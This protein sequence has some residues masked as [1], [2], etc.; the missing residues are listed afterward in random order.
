[1]KI[2]AN[3]FTEIK[4]QSLAQLDVQRITKQ[5]ATDKEPVLSWCNGLLFNYSFA[6]KNPEE[7]DTLIRF[8]YFYFAKCEKITTSIWN[9]YT[10]EV[11]DFSGVPLFENIAKYVQEL[12]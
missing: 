2:S 1:M 8:D 11:H 6:E 7:P 10:I 3:Y 9:G 12:K 5:E 4:I